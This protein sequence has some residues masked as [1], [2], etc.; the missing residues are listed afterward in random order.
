MYWCQINLWQVFLISVMFQPEIFVWFVCLFFLLV[1][2]IKSH[3]K[4]D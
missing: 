2:F 4:K 3:R 1:A